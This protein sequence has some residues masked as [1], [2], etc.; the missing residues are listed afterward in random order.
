MLSF[1]LSATILLCLSIH[2]SAAPQVVTGQAAGQ[3]MFLKKR[4][5]PK[6]IDDLGVWAKE[7]RARLQA[8]YG[9]GPPHKRSAGTNL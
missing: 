7:H 1:P 5:P 8:K 3:T 4:A 2:A 9:D 6:T